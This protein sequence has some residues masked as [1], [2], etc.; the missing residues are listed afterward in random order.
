[1]KQPTGHL[2]NVS[3]A[4]LILPVAKNGINKN[5]NIIAS[6]DWFSSGGG[7]EIKV[8]LTLP[9]FDLAVLCFR[10][11]VGY[12]FHSFGSDRECHSDGYGHRPKR[13]CGCRRNGDRDKYDD[14]DT[15]ECRQRYTRPI[16][17]SRFDAGY[18]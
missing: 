12:G 14:W 11:L 1:M 13:S 6:V 16:H 8:E 18:L 4:Y 10:F 15:E 3:L 5:A 9:I 17:D 2:N 7:D